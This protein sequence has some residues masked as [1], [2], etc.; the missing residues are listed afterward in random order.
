MQ[1]GTETAKAAIMAVR[2]PN[3]NYETSASS[4]KTGGPMLKQPTFDRKSTNPL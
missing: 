4:D 1:A 2:D 3:Q